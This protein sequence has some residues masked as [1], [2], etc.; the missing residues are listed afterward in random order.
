MFTHF[1]LDLCFISLEACRASFGEKNETNQTQFIHH[2]QTISLFDILQY[3]VASILIF[4]VCQDLDSSR[5]SANPHLSS[6]WIC[7]SGASRDILRHPDFSDVNLQETS[8]KLKAHHDGGVPTMLDLGANFHKKKT[9]IQSL[10]LSMF[11]HP[12]FFFKHD[13]CY[14][15][16][17]TPLLLLMEE[18]LHH[19]GCIRSCKHWDKLPICWCRISSIDS[20]L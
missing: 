20:I 17:S 19:L 5:S 3:H 10:W 15:F 16:R 13:L 2:K 18:I 4:D 9:S 7:L 12:Q 6:D 11:Y 8:W 14:K 1:A